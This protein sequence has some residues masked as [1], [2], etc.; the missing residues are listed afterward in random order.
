MSFGAAKRF[1]KEAQV[2]EADGGYSVAL[3]GRAVKTPAKKALV[4]PTRALAQAV[5]AEW[6]AQEDRVNPLTM[7][8]TRGANAAIDKVA[9]QFDEV[10]TMLLAYGD[11]DLLCY[12]ADSPD[13]LVARQAQGW[14]PLLDWA[15]ARFG[16]RL[17][18]RTGVMH[19]AQDPRA[20]A[21]LE[22][23]VRRMTPF[24]LAAFHDLVSIS[25]SLVLALAVSEAHLKAET[26]WDLS[27]I[28]E[29][30]Q[31]EQWGV[32]DEAARLAARKR[33][34][35]LQAKVFLDLCRRGP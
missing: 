23:P 18:P 16:A 4:V 8:V 22:D 31:E 27:R 35:F 30:W 29:T 9:V 24:E 19:A 21:A 17:A 7:P 6:D 2:V 15:D 20:L 1:W 13:G 34:D 12:R 33:G 11:A 3:D 32:D 26:A 25:G 10:A 5:A 28:D 14:D